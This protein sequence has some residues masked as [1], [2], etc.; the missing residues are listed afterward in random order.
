M[1]TGKEHTRL[2]I[3]LEHARQGAQQDLDPFFGCEPGDKADDLVA[4]KVQPVGKGLHGFGSSI[5]YLDRW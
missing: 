2:G 3:N 5:W 1:L 4:V